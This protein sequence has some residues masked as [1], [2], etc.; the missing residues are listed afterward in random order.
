MKKLILLFL[1]SV[2][3]LISCAENHRSMIS[4]YAVTSCYDG[5][6]LS[7]QL[8]A[9]FNQPCYWQVLPGSRVQCDGFDR[10]GRWVS[11]WRACGVN[12]Y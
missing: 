4:C 7:C 12:M 5:F 2:F 10:W 3:P 1:V 9:G 8:D 11:V 6:V